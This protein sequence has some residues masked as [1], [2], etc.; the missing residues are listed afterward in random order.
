MA[1]V[2]KKGRFYVFS[3]L[4]SVH[5]IK[6]L[7]FFQII[8]V[9]QIRSLLTVFIFHTVFKVLVVSIEFVTACVILSVLKIDG[10]CEA[11]NPL[12]FDSF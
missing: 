12:R 10:K 3:N 8:S 6:G 7:I 11:E 1:S 2:I 9:Q 5:L 4:F